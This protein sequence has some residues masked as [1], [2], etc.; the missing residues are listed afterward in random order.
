MLWKNRNELIWQQRSREPTDLVQSAFSVLNQWKSVQDRTFDRF[1]G[2]MTNEDGAEHWSLP[3]PGRVKVNTDAAIFEDTTCF[4]YAFVAR[5]QEGA[6][7]EARSRCSFGRPDPELAEAMGIREAL[8][9]IKNFSYANVTVESD[10][11][12][13]V[14][15]IRSSFLCYSYLGRVIKECRV[16]LASLES[17]S[18]KLIFV[19]RS[20]NNV[21]HY[22]AKH[23]CSIADRRWRVGDIHPE[24]HY[25][26]LNDLSNE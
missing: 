16:L 1:L 4:S 14:Q 6:L 10:C 8:T 24:L 17:K 11:L 25:V 12:Q 2:H 5:D 13:V 7:I 19:K 18:I 26:L 23:N 9:W 21:A 22:L 20:A 3:M 15:A